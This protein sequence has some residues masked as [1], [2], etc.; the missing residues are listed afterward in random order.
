MLIVDLPPWNLENGLTVNRPLLKD[1]QHMNL[2][3]NMV[4]IE[5]PCVDRDQFSLSNIVPDVT[6]L[7]NS[8]IFGCSVTLHSVYNHSGRNLISIF[9]ISS[10]N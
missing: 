2:M 10:S 9:D 8:A 6:K 1:S 4:K 3:E 7:Y 5:Y